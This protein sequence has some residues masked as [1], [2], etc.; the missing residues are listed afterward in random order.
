M[1]NSSKRE[2]RPNGMSWA[3]PVGFMI[4]YLLPVLLWAREPQWVPMPNRAPRPATEILVKFRTQT[5]SGMISQSL[6][7]VP[8]LGVE[9]F[10]VPVSQTA[11]AAMAA[12][13]HQA[14]VEW[15]QPN[16]WRYALA[17]EVVPDDP[18]YRPERNDRRY[19]QWYL[20]KINANYAWS[21]SQGRAGAAVAVVDSGVDLN[22]PDLRGRLL[23]GV[24]LVHQDNYSPPALGMDDNGHGTHVA[25]IIAA[26]A[27]NH[28]GIAG[29]AWQGSVIPV[30]VLNSNGEGTDADIAAGI[31]WGADAGANIINLSLGGIQADDQ[32]PAVLQDAVEYA[33]GRGCLVVAASGNSG[34]RSKVYPADL[35]H[36]VA[37]GATDP[38]DQRASYSTYGPDL[39]LA[40]PGG[41]GGGLFSRDTGILSTYWNANSAASDFFSGSEAGEYAVMAGTSMAAALVSG[42]SLVVWGAHPDWTAEQVEESLRATAFDIGSPGADEE[43]GSGRV[44]LLAALGNSPVEHRELETYNYPNP[45]S[46]GRDSQTQIVFWLRQPQAVTV[47][48]YTAAREW[49]WE[50]KLAASQVVEGKNTV[51]WDGCDQS[52]RVVGNGAYY[53]RIAAESGT[54]SAVKV[55]AVL[56]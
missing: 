12:W 39:K 42:A 33:F 41:A 36:V 22:H 28:L 17:A 4:F 40:A 38:W 48:I 7:K 8:G 34:D 31:V 50:K 46:P 26:R 51:S 47:R 27:G 15:V 20:P 56:R 2:R 35:A 52:G 24:T 29:C 19:Q 18:F 49:I 5:P 3:R 9:R 25:G 21:L 11:E 54:A 16:V 14:G 1:I 13:R 6:G 30:K 55:I 44:D 23:P 43:T 45:F 37:V 32:P 10:P 53:F